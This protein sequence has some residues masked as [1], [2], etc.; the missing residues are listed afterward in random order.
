GFG[1]SPIIGRELA[2][3]SPG[4]VVGGGA[5]CAIAS[6]WVLDKNP[7]ISVYPWM[8]FMFQG[9][10]SVPIVTWALKKEASGLLEDLH[11]GKI[12]PP[13]APPTGVGGRP[14][15]A[16]AFGPC[17]KIPAPFKTT[18]YYLGII[19]L[20]GALN[21]ALLGALA[22]VGIAINVNVTA[23]LFGLLLGSLGIMD[24]AP[25]FRSDSYGLLLLGLMGLMANT[26]AHNPPGNML[27]LIPPLLL[28]F[29]VSTAVLTAAGVIAARLLHFRPAR[30]I[31]LTMNCMMGFP[32]NGMLVA[33]AA[34][35]GTNEQE[36]G[37][38]TAAL[39]PLLGLGTMLISNAVSILVVSI[40]VG[41]V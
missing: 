33:N 39:S 4:S 17:A 40:M 6:R 8:I 30:G 41:M 22:S 37:F 18:A 14:G 35:L 21:K 27:R 5:S 20:A 34:K 1:L 10:F 11:S 7:G 12:S 38:L 26:L 3:L 9:L 32:V 19:M 2:L 29:V 13:A 24:R 25:L 23:L 31:A 16:P 15:A 36:R 28:A